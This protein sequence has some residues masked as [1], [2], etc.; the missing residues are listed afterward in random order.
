MWR[1]TTCQKTQMLFCKD[2]LKNKSMMK[3]MLYGEDVEI[4]ALENQNK[5]LSAFYDKE[6]NNPSG[7]SR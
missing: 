6:K 1:T 2:A 4:K 7:I 3:Q 5:I